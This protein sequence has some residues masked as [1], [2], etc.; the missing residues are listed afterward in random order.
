MSGP[1]DAMNA[2]WKNRKNAQED[3]KRISKKVKAKRQAAE[4]V[5]KEIE[6]HGGVESAPEDLVEELDALKEEINTL[7]DDLESAKSRSQ[8]AFLAMEEKSMSAPLD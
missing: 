6:E 1:K 8:R 5:S 2:H 4:K 7:E 3:I